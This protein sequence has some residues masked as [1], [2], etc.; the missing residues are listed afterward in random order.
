[1]LLRWALRHRLLTIGAAVLVFAGALSLVPHIGREFMPPLNEGDLM[2]M[3]IASASVSLD[4]NT[5]IARRQN[6][7]IGR[8]PEVKAVVAKIGRADTSTDPSPLNMTETIVAL[9]PRDEWR[10]GLTIYSGVLVVVLVIGMAIRGGS[11]EGDE[12]ARQVSTTMRLFGWPPNSVR[13]VMLSLLVMVICSESC[14]ACSLMSTVKF[15][16]RAD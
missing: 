13:L 1:P 12:R 6:A 5:A 3:P 8:F 14:P 2:F 4:E 15:A 16:R 11:V 9:K 7:A 10:P